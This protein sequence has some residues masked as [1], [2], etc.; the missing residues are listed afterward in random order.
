V[1]SDEHEGSI[2]A[3]DRRQAMAWL[4]AGE[5]PPASLAAA[6]D[7][8]RAEGMTTAT[9]LAAVRRNAP[10]LRAVS[11]SEGTARGPD[12]APRLAAAS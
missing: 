6:V 8:L 7:A 9:A 11:D 1:G 5:D 10:A 2:T 3:E 12:P 4:A